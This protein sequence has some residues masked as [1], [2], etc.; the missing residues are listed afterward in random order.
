MIS[1]HGSDLLQ[2]IDAF[3]TEHKRHLFFGLMRVFRRE[4]AILAV[5]LITHVCAGFAS[6]FG[7]KNLLQ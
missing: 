1:S 6:P 7:I 2:H 4:Y 5:A 3:V